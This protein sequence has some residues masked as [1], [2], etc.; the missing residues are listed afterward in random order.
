MAYLWTRGYELYKQGVL[1]NSGGWL[2][3]TDKFVSIMLFIDN[4][5]ESYRNQNGKK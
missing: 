3:Q 4:K 5:I 2:D 1:P